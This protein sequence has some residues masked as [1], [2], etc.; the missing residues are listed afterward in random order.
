MH[1][2]TV[3]TRHLGPR[4]C[5]EADDN[6]SLEVNLS[7]LNRL[8]RARDPPQMQ[9]T[10]AG[11]NKL[12]SVITSAVNSLS[13]F[14][15]HTCHVPPEDLIGVDKGIQILIRSRYFENSP[16]DGTYRIPRGPHQGNVPQSLFLSLNINQIACLPTLVIAL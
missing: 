16:G 2:A 10:F 4:R 13:P 7:R 3:V 8:P 12:K 1:P 15:V 5:F 6:H 11:H 14:P 9:R